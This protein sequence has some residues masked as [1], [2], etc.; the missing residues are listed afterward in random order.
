MGNYTPSP[1]LISIR[2]LKIFPT[3]V[4]LEGGWDFKALMARLIKKGTFRELYIEKTVR[5]ISHR[6]A[7][8]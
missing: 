3:A 5:E 2:F 8:R 6:F 4:K 7:E 1:L